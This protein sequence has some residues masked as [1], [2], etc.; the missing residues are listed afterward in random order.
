MIQYNDFAITLA[1]PDQ[2]AFGDEKWMNILKR[3]GIVKNLNFK[4]GHAAILLVSADT[5]AIDYYDFGR[6]IAPRGDGRARSKL[7]DPRLHIHTTALFGDWRQPIRNLDAI[8]SELTALEEATHGGGRLLFSVVPGISYLSAKLFADQLVQKGPIPYG[9]LAAENNSCSR[10]VAQ[11]LIAGML[12]Q[13]R[14]IR[15]L[16]YPETLKP[17]PVSN[18][19]NTRSDGEI[20]CYSNHELKKWK[21]N[22]MRSLHFHWQMLKVNFSRKHSTMLACDKGSGHLSHPDRPDNLTAGAQWIGGLGEGMW[23]ELTDD[24]PIAHHYMIRS[25]TRSGILIGQV[26]VECPQR[27][28]NVHLPYEITAQMD[29]EYFTFLQNG[30]KYLFKQAQDNTIQQSLKKII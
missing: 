1:W 12:P 27:S 13:D 30:S 25:Y 15:K 20:Y 3:V 24:V 9:A 23:F 22:R 2:T 16:K 17:S 4:V 26:Y 6:Y 21:I 18:V 19:V 11:V 7:F 8:L 10:F 14:R 28:F 29:G 5:G